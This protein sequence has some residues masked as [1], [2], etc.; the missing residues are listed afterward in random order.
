M[1]L[2]KK[3]VFFLQRFQINLTIS[4]H[5]CLYNFSYPKLSD[6]G[7]EWYAV[8]AIANMSLDI[9]GME[10]TCTPFNGWY[11]KYFFTSLHLRKRFLYIC[12]E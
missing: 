6:L 3:I 4:P 1:L 7:L 5:S 11:V 10:F 8:P 12:H 9:A 2:S